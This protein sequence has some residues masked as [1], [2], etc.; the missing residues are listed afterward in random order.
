MRVDFKIDKKLLKK[1]MKVTGLDEAQSIELGL[2]TLVKLAE[3]EKLLDLRGKV[4]W[5]G[6]PDIVWTD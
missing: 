3:Q 2:K 5:E 6:D 1:V 4:P